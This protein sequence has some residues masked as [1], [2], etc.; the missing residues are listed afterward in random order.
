MFCIQKRKNY[1]LLLFQN[2]TQNSEK[3]IIILV[4]SNREQ[5]WHYLAVKN[6]QHYKEE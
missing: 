5:Q 6:Y 2:I 1:I 3:Q 4:I